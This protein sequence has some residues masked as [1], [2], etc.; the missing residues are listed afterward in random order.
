MD[1]LDLGT[2]EIDKAAAALEELIRAKRAEFAEGSFPL[3]AFE[4]HVKGLASGLF[5]AAGVTEEHG[6]PFCGGG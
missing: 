1:V 4:W 6:C 2:E 3:S 5:E